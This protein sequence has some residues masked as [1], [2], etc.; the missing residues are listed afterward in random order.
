[1][2]TSV[3]FLAV[4]CCCAAVALADV[5]VTSKMS[6][7]AMGMSMGGSTINIFVSGDKARMVT[8]SEMSPMMALTPEGPP[9]A[10]YITR[11]DKGEY[12]IVY[13]IDS[14]YAVTP[15]SDVQQLATDS[16]SADMPGIAPGDISWDLSS[17]K[18]NDST[19]NGY[20]CHGVKVHGAVKI[21]GIQ[22]VLEFTAWASDDIPGESEL[23]AFGKASA[24]KTGIDK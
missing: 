14:S 12:W 3:I 22:Q 11:L 10:I 17:E 5:T 16:S 21:T 7:G 6:M 13:D 24:E 23:E 1:M 8:E 9:E 15:L 20:S 19:I 2:K 18:L 4:F